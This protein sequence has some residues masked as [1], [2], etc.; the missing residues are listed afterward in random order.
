MKKEDK[1]MTQELALALVGLFLI[2]SLTNILATLKTL[3]IS[4]RIMNPVYFIVFVDAM[5][6][7][8]VITKVTSSEGLHF[9]VVYALGRTFGV[10][11]GGKIEGKM[12]L[13]IIEVDLFLKNKG[14]M[15]KLAET[16]RDAGYTVNNYVARGQN[17]DRRYKVEVV[18]KRKEFKIL[19]GIM[20]DC[21]VDDPTFKIKNLSKVDG[22]IST[23][24][25]QTA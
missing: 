11:I 1:I 8:T 23:S 21:G 12:A 9:T 15:I 20:E 14:K 17:G 18:L 5:I 22:K 7:A 6:F 19:E 25:L 24:S 2:T 3:L 16:L 4:K 13:G 10:F